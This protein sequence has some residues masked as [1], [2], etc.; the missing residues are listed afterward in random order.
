M[1]EGVG[2]SVIIMIVAIFLLVVSG[3]LAFS[4]TYNKAFRVKNK[5][6]SVLE[7]EQGYNDD[8]IKKIET[9]L[10]EVGYH[11]SKPQGY[12]SCYECSDAGYCIKWNKT[13]SNELQSGYFDV[14]TSVTVDIPIINR[15]MPYMKIL[16]ITG[17][18]ITIYPTGTTNIRWTE[19][20]GC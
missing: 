16:N 8:A 20:G 5:I 4:V 7:Q 19:K 14:V 13:G 9:A 1:S 12:D 10:K 11:A 3:Y 17:S 15:I 18:T 6:I 2:G